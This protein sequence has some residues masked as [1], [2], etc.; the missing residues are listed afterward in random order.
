[1]CIYFVGTVYLGIEHSKSV[2]HLAW[3]HRAK[4][5]YIGMELGI[6][7]GTLD[8]IEANHRKV[9][10]CLTSVINDWLRNGKPRPTMGAITAALQ[11]DRVSRATGSCRHI[12]TG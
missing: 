10:D 2:L 4:W 3:E 11:S 7:A 12:I 8:A 1:M 5:R 9:E 6:D